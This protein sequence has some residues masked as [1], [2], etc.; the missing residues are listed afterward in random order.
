[1]PLKIKKFTKADIDVKKLKENF[2]YRLYGVES[3]NYKAF[4]NTPNNKGVITAALGRFQYLPTEHGKDIINYAK[5]YYGDKF[6]TIVSKGAIN[7]NSSKKKE[8]WDWL[9]NDKDFQESYFD[10]KFEKWILPD[11]LEILNAENKKINPGSVDEIAQII[12]YR[13]S[14]GAKDHYVNGNSKVE[15]NNMEFQSYK[16]KGKENLIKN[17]LTPYQ[18]VDLTSTQDKLKLTNDY[19]RKV[20]AINK[21]DK[22]N[23]YKESEI[24]ELISKYTPFEKEI[25]NAGIKE[26]YSPEAFEKQK[27]QINAWTSIQ[28]YKIKNK[29][30]D[31]DFKKV[32]VYSE[33]PLKLR[34]DFEKAFGVKALE[35]NAN[36]TYYNYFHAVENGGSYQLPDK[37]GNI[38]FNGINNTGEI[39]YGKMENGNRYDI[40]KEFSINL[41]KEYEDYKLKNDEVTKT[42]KDD[43]TLTDSRKSDN[44]LKSSG[45]QEIEFLNKLYNTN[46]TLAYLPVDETINTEEEI[47][48]TPDDVV[49][50]Y[51]PVT[52]VTTNT[53]VE[54]PYVFSKE[55]VEKQKAEEDK[56]SKIND[57]NELADYYN[58][59]EPLEKNT[60]SYDKNNYKKEIP[61]EPLM[62]LAVALSGKSKMNTEI[63]LHNET[64][65]QGF[66]NY[67]AD[68]NK[69]SKTGLPPEVEAA[70]KSKIN[71]V[72]KLGID[73][74]VRASAGNRNLVLGNLGQLDAGKMQ[75]LTDLSLA[76]YEA[77]NKA[78]QSLWGSNEIC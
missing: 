60:L 70:S 20:D 3:T 61:F 28:Q 45:N 64:I 74:I 58:S 23:I 11:T 21:L 51:T 66:L 59:L 75:A 16:D 46:R 34:N 65:N 8:D 68:L 57:V 13:G 55:Y 36:G 63:P 37:K 77:K 1:M 48:E 52:P 32:Q 39:I 7:K 24:T 33:I 10:Y 9:L 22:D 43:V 19:K 56:S 35:K 12:H 14:A 73:N 69:I 41:K 54:Q 47:P 49:T 4:N 76:D 67:M 71:E 2:K 26:Y 31:E 6:G 72:Y 44:Y 17:N 30:S 15:S 42:K 62:G 38:Y 29:I 25:I 18:T 40:V 78:F 5:T 50:P 27:S 53:K